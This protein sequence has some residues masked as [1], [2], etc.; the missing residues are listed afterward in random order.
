[1]LRV[2]DTFTKNL[3][4]KA[5]V[6]YMDLHFQKYPFSM[7]PYFPN[8]PSVFLQR[9]KEYLEQGFADC[10]SDTLTADKELLMKIGKLE[11]SQVLAPHLKLVVHLK[12][13]SLQEIHK[14]SFTFFFFFF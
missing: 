13:N 4:K 8:K 9:C 1:M 12:H 2:I 6:K 10:Y 3:S 7:C 14:T 5:H 11:L